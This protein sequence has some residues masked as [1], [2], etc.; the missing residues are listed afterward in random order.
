MDLS[1]LSVA[2]ALP[3]LPMTMMAASARL[4]GLVKPTFELGARIFGTVDQHAYHG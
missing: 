4:I 1:Y 3:Q 2:D